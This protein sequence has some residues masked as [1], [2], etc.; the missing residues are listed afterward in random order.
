MKILLADDQELMLYSFAGILADEFPQA[1]ICKVNCGL[2]LEKMARTQTFDIIISDMQMPDKTGFAVLKQL[3]A[4][5]IKTPFLIISSCP[6]NQYAQRVLKAGGNG[7]F[8]KSGTH[9]NFIIAVQTI[10]SGK[11]YISFQATQNMAF[12]F[13]ENQIRQ[14]HQ[15]ISDRELEILKHISCGKHLSEIAHLLSLSLATINTY[16]QRLLKKMHLTTTA[17]LMHYAIINQLQN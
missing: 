9:Q 11:K 2:Q 5:Q 15:L 16:R 10:L 3:R 17:E 1:T 14:A 8:V 12:E 4:Q 13:D 7:Y 6:E